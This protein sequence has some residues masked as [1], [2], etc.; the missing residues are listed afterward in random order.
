MEILLDTVE[1]L[2]LNAKLSRL[3]RDPKVQE[4]KHY[5]QHG[6]VTTY[7]HAK[8]VTRMCFYLNRRFHLH[9]DE[10]AL[11]RGA[12]LHDFYLYDWHDGKLIRKIHGFQHP[13]IARENAVQY[14]DIT[15][16]E[17]KMIQSHMW[18]LTIAR[19]PTNREAWI[20]CFADKYVSTHETLFCRDDG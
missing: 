3:I 15:I 19:I 6:N 12:M 2:E 7:E 10:D 14:F 11:I 17:Q 4:M 1:E 8:S 9:A 13:R 5:I 20:L 16:R 18:P